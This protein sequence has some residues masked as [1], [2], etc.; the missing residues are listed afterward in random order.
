MP[1]LPTRTL[2]D[3]VIT[4]VELL[5]VNDTPTPD[6]IDAVEL[7]SR[8][9]EFSEDV[10]TLTT[11]GTTD[12]HEKDTTDKFRVVLDNQ[13]FSVALD[14]IGMSKVAA[15][16]T[17]FYDGSA[18]KGNY[19]LRLTF[20]ATDEADGSEVTIVRTFPKLTIKKYTGR[21]G[22][23]RKSVP[24]QRTE[25]NAVKAKVDLLNVAIPDV[26]AT[27]AYFYDKEAA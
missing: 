9:V 12:T 17:A 2:I 3:Q 1:A 15:D 23:T 7:D 6:T 10:T 25:F 8:A 14:Q 11:E 16:G 21:D 22:A 20:S 26:P 13:V 19:G 5:Y 27:G 24:S 4:L 18:G